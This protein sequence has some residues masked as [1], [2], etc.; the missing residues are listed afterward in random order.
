GATPELDCLTGYISQHVQQSPRWRSPPPPA[1]PDSDP[2]QPVEAAYIIPRGRV[3]DD[4]GSNPCPH[5]KR[6]QGTDQA[7]RG[8]GKETHEPFP[9]NPEVPQPRAGGA[10]TAEPM[11]P[12]SSRD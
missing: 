7:A 12:L 4:A 10:S 8:K 11:R 6:P 3:V 1:L 2:K 5:A 9:R